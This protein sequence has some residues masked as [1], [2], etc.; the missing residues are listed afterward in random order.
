MAVTQGQRRRRRR[1]ADAPS[2]MP[3]AVAKA[4]TSG[5]SPPRARR[6]VVVVGGGITMP[7]WVRSWSGGGVTGRGSTTPAPPA[8]ASRSFSGSGRSSASAWSRAAKAD[9]VE[10]VLGVGG[11]RLGEH[12]GQR[13]QGVVTGELGADARHER[14]DRRVGGEGHHPGDRFV[15]HEGQGVDVGATVDTVPER[16]LGRGVTGRAH[17]RP[18]RL[19]Q[20]RLGQR[21]GEA[22]VG[23]PETTLPRRRGGWRVSRRGGRSR[24]RARR[25]GLRPPGPRPRPP[26]TRLRRVPSSSMSRSDPP[27]RNSSTRKGPGSSSPQ[28]WTARTCALASDAADCASARNRR[29][30]PPSAAS[31]GCRTLMA[32]RRCSVVSNAANT[33]ADAPLPS[34]DSIR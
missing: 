18:R 4:S 9:R 8:P 15:E 13:P 28:S 34:A 12:L 19:G 32:T 23:D 26:A 33:F 11:G 3:T 31:A 6:P 25:R 21:S 1:A 14:R 10:P 30:K 24:G 17:R 20:R 22:E 2:A 29:R 7:W 27:P 16:L 5:S